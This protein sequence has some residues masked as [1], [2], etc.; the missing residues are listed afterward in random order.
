MEMLFEGI[1]VK[2]EK[3]FLVLTFSCVNREAL[4]N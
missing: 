3:V 4:Y 2:K 1:R